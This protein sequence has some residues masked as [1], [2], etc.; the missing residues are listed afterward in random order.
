MLSQDS[1][2]RSSVPE[3]SAGEPVGLD[4]QR[5]DVHPLEEARSFKAL[6][7]LEEPEYSIEQIAAKIGKPPAYVATRLKLTE[8]AETVVEEFYR[9][10]IGVGHA[11][12]LA[13]LPLDKQEEGLKACFRE[14]WAAT[15]DRKAKRILLPVRSLQAWIEQN[16][17]LILKDAPFD[18]RDAHLVDIAGACTDCSKRTGHNKLLFADL[19]KQDACKLCGIRATASIFRWLVTAARTA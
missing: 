2:V 3:Y 13:K 7:D 10:E 5:R 16:I 1:S 9:E 12:L 8:L 11:L 6:L 17:L 15:S 18:K 4:L 14:D 19:G